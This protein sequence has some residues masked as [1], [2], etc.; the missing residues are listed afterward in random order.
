MY[1][2]LGLGT[3]HWVIDA[4]ETPPHMLRNAQPKTDVHLA[5][6][7]HAIVLF[8]RD[9]FCCCAAT[10]LCTLAEALL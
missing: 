1:I 4:Y 2:S 10:V 3:L 8:C 5:V 7:G 6:R 9:I